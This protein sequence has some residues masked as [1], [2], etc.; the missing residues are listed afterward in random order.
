MNSYALG[1]AILVQALSDANYGGWD[2]REIK[3]HEEAV[4]WFTEAGEDFYFVCDM[5]GVSPAA[6]LE[7]FKRWE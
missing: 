5:A 6:I 7:R 3:A 4:A 1:R 2:A